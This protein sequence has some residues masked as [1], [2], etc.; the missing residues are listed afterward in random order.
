[1]FEKLTNDIKEAAKIATDSVRDI[2]DAQGSCNMDYVF[3]HVDGNR[4]QIE[5]AI[6]KAGF[7]PNTSGKDRSFV[8]IPPVHSQG[9]KRKTWAQTFSREM[10]KRGYSSGA[11]YISE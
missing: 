7:V 3:L 9:A 11:V 4:M 2:D 8:I 5:A 1:M 6:K 10:E